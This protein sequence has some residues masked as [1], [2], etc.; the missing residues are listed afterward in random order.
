MFSL[1]FLQPKV[2]L[3]KISF[4]LLFILEKVLLKWNFTITLTLTIKSNL[5]YHIQTKII[6]LNLLLIYSN[7]IQINSF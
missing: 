6:L 4:E 3:G 1:F 5:F 2:L 7:Q